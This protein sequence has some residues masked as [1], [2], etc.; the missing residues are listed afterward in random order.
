VEEGSPLLTIESPDQPLQAVAYCSADEG[1]QIRAGMEVQ[2]LPAGTREGSSRHFSGRVESAGRFP[3]TRAA[4][5]RSLKSEAWVDN[6]LRLGPVVEVVVNLSPPH[7]LRDT[8]SG[9]PCRV[10]IT[11]NRQRPIQF[12]LPAGGG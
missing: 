6:F 10:R 5:I 4:M 3:A 2:V 7:A 8:F 9:T 1:Y 12:L 11:V